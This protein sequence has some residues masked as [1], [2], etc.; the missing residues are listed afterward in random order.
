MEI[1]MS[2]LE[3]SE[4]FDYV[5][6]G[7]GTAGCIVAA[8]L[9]E[10]PNVKVLLLEA[11]PRALGNIWMYIPVGYYKNVYNPEVT[12]QYVADA[13]PGA[14]NR[15]IPW[16]KGRVLG[17]S[18]AINGLT[19][20]R[21]KPDDYD[22]WAK[23]GN[24]G[25]SYREVLPYFR[26]FE[27]FEKGE[28]SFHGGRGPIGVR[29]MR[30]HNPICD[31][32]V[33]GGRQLGLPY[34]EDLNS[35]L[36]EGVGTY[37]LCIK[38]WRRSSSADHITQAMNRKNLVVRLE[39]YVNR[40]IFEGKR[41]VGVEYTS[42]DNITHTV[43]ATRE[44]ILSGG[45]ISSP[46]LLQLSGVGPA[47]L[48]QELGISVVHDLPGVGENL[49]DH[50]Q[51]R[52]A[53]K[54]NLPRTMND[55]NASLFKQAVEG[56]KYVFRQSGVATVGAGQ[57]G[58]FMRSDPNGPVDMEITFM[59]FT[60]DG[61]GRPPHPFS[62]FTIV[63]FQQQPESKGHVRIR[64]KEPRDFPSMTANYLSAEKDQKVIVAALKAGRAFAATPALS[65]YITEEFKPGKD[66]QTDEEILSY[67]R[68]QGGTVF[69]LSSSCRMGSDPMAVVDDRLRVHGIDGL[70][71]V[72]ASAMPTSVSANICAAVMM[73]GEKGADLIKEDA[74]ATM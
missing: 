10:N 5:V 64:S 35:D 20:L 50:Y 52:S 57:A 33:E 23:M 55:V 45:A 28:N 24:K 2:E 53:Y 42:R 48:L 17:G 29:P 44:V 67:A 1:A 71:V 34:I 46:Q 68:S 26:K 7:G 65:R 39:S 14:D 66:V 49:I 30:N 13:D 4:S 32:F 47:D 37:Q 9:S 41:A 61:P 60:T 27:K 72:D 25:W 63:G 3:G 36:H 73:V 56:I 40:I 15:K 43:R 16:P 19:H 54:A 11:G 21:G 22:N 38:D 51:V 69:H 12:F 62:A 70:R 74:R 8:R 59:N 18:S 31:A 58:A 6:V